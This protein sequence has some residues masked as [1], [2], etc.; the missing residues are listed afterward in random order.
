[1]A[2]KTSQFQVPKIVL[3]GDPLY[4][5]PIFLLVV[6]LEIF[7][8]TVEYAV[9]LKLQKCLNFNI[10]IVQCTTT[11]EVQVSEKV[12]FLIPTYLR[13]TELQK[14]TV[15]QCNDDSFFSFLFPTKQLSLVLKSIQFQQLLYFWTELKLFQLK[16][17]CASFAAIHEI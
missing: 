7:C 9:H 13:H 2:I 10:Q 17:R 8:F 16:R 14:V 4:I 12:S 5:L 6:E 3:S 11:T 15:L 1:M